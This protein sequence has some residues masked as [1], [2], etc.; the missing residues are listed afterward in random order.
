MSTM[1]LTQ[2]VANS[3]VYARVTAAHRLR[4]VRAWSRLLVCVVGVWLSGCVDRQPEVVLPPVER[5][6]DDVMARYAPAAEQRLRPYFDAAGVPYPPT[7]LALLGFKEE[8]RL[9]VWGPH[10]GRWVFLRAYPMLAASGVAGPKLREGDEQVPEGMYRIEALNPQSQFHL[11]MKLDYPNAADRQQASQEGREQL[12]G[13]IFLH[14]KDVS[15]GCVALGD[16]AIEEL[17]VLVVRVGME[18]VTVLLAPYDLRQPGGGRTEGLPLWV[19]ALYAEL[20]RA[21]AH[22]PPSPP[23]L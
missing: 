21:L 5:T 18:R 16:T 4:I 12:G 22:F 23:A 17:F 14:G 8:K 2:R 10:A 19:V 15:V 6:V 20:R 1:E 11:S 3:T 9:E 13:D 7:A